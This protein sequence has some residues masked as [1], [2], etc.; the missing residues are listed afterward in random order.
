MIEDKL[1]DAISKLAGKVG[2]RVNS[3]VL[4]GSRGKAE[5]LPWSDVDLLIISEG[6]SNM[7]RWDRVR[8]VL[9]N[10]DYEKPVE[11]VCLA[12]NEVSETNPFIWEV[13]REGVAVMDD[14]TF[15][16]LR[17]KCLKYLDENG[18]QRI[19]YGYVKRR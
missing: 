18:F 11:P 8:L 16:A 17:T 1:S 15:N 12:P 6:F 14:G 5:E 2:L 19:K 10:W 4:F 9:E 7:K 3:I 13:C